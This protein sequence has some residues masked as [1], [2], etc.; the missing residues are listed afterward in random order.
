MWFRELIP[1]FELANVQRVGIRGGPR[2]IVRREGQYAFE[3]GRNPITSHRPATGIRDLP[4]VYRPCHVAVA[5]SEQK[6]DLI[7]GLTGE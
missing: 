2:R 1:S 3:L 7:D 6:R 4:D 5:M